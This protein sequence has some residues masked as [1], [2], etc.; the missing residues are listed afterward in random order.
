MLSAISQTEKTNTH[1]A[2]YIWNPKERKK[3]KKERKVELRKRE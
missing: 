1:G 3:K 2:A